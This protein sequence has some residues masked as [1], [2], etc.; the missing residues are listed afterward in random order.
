MTARLDMLELLGSDYL[1]EHVLEKYNEERKES[2]YRAYTSDML[3][4]I[5]ESMG[6]TVESRY[7]D[8]IEPGQP[9][10]MDA[11]EIALDII[12]RAGL[13]V[14]NGLINTEGDTWA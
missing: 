3:M 5:A 2:A 13:K 9:E 11:D 7:V 14:Q 12:E 6:A 8:L 4:A 10:E 1:V